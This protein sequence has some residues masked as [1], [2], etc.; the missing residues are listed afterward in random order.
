MKTANKGISVMTG[1]LNRALQGWSATV[2]AAAVVMLGA[3]TARAA[4]YIR[5]NNTDLLNTAAAWGGTLPTASDSVQWDATCGANRSTTLGG[6]VNWG[7][8]IVTSPGGTITIANT[9]SSTINLTGL[10]GTGIDMSAAT[11]NLTIDNPVA[12]QASQTWNVGA[13]RTLTVGNYAIS[14]SYGLTKS[15]SGTLT[16]SG[17]NTYTG[18]TTISGGVLSINGENR[19]G[20]TP[21]SATPGYLTFDGGTLKVTGS[22]AITLS[23]NR[24]VAITSNNGTIDNAMATQNFQING[25]ITNAPGHVGALTINNTSGGA[26]VPNSQ[27]TYS[28][29][30]TLLTGLTVPLVNSTGPAG[31][32]TSGPYGT[33]TL[34]L[35]GGQIRATT[36]V[37]ITIANPVVVANDTTFPTISNEKSLTFTGPVTLTGNRTL[38]VNIGATVSSSSLIISGAIGEDTAGRTLTKAGTGTLTLSTN[39]TYTGKTTVSGGTLSF[40]T[41]RNVN[42]GA[43]ALGAP[44]TVADGTVDVAGTLTY[45]GAALSSDRVINLTGNTTFY[46]NGSGLLTLTGGFTGAGLL[47]FRGAQSFAVSGAIT[48]SGGVNKTDDGT[49]TLSNAANSFGNVVINRGTISVNSIADA[50]VNSALGAGSTITLGQSGFNN[51]GKLQFTGAAGGASDRAINIQ[52]NSG[53]TNGGII[54]N[55]VAGQTLTLDGNVTTGGTGTTPSLQLTGAGN[56]VMSGTIAGSGLTLT[57]AGTGT[58][59]LS[60]D[61][62]FSGATTVSAGTLT[63]AGTGRLGGGSYAG[64]ITLAEG[65]TL[66]DDSTADQTLSSEISGAGALRKSQASTLTLGGVNTYTGMTTV[67]GG[68]LTLNGSLQRAKM[69]ITSGTVNGNGTI[70]YRIAGALSDFIAVSGSGTIN[71]ANLTLNVVQDD[72]PSAAEYVIIS[73]AGKVTG[74]SFGTVNLP[75]AFWSVDYDGTTANPGA[76][77]LVFDTA[78]ALSTWDGETSGSWALGQN[79][80]ANTTPMNGVPLLFPA[81]AGN[82]ANT[83]DLLTSVFSLALEGGYT[84]SGNALALGSSV[85][86]TGVN[87][88]ALPLS[89]GAGAGTFDVAGELTLSGEVSGAGGIAKTGSGTLVISGVNSYSGATAVSGGTLSM[90][91]TAPAAPVAG[92]ALWLDGADA[93]TFWADSVGGTPAS[94]GGAV[95]AWSDKSGNNY[96]TTQVT[97]DKRPTYQ[98][99]VQNGR[100]VLR[101]DATDDGMTNT[102]SVTSGNLTLFVVYTCR[103]AV[104][105]NRRVVQGSANWLIG[106]YG[107]YY[108][109]HPGTWI[110]AMTSPVLDNE[111]VLQRVIQGGGVASHFV[112]GA[113][114]G[115]VS[116]AIYPGTL[117]VGATTTYNEPIGGD[118]A[119]LLVYTTALTAEQVGAIE[120]YLGAKWGG[121]NSSIPSTKSLPVTTALSLAPGDLDLN[122]RSVSIGSLA[123]DASAQVRLNG[124]WLTAGNDNTTTT[125]SGTIING[126]AAGGGLYKDG[127]GDL[128]LA[129]GSANTFTGDTVLRRGR[130]GL[131]KTGGAALGGNIIGINNLSPDLYTT[132]DNQFA[133]GAVMYS[134]GSVTDYFRFELMGTTQTLAGIVDNTGRGVI[135]HREQVTTVPAVGPLSTLILNGS[136]TYVFNGHLRDNGGKL[137]LAMNGTGTQTLSGANITYTGTTTVNGG[138]LICT[139]GA[140]TG[141]AGSSVGV[142]SYMTINNG[143]T[144]DNRL[145]GPLTVWGTLR[146]IDGAAQTIGGDITLNGGALESGSAVG[147]NATYGTFYINPART[148]TANGAG[149]TISGSNNTIGIETGRTLT[150]DTPLATDA[151][152]V[153]G[154]IVRRND[155]STSTG[156]IA[157]NGA[158]TVTLSA[159]DNNYLGSTTINGGILS[160]TGTKTGAGAVTVNSGGTLAGTG[161]I[162]GAVTVAAGGRVAPGAGGVGKLTLSAARTLQPGSELVVEFNATP[163]NDKI[164]GAAAVT[165]NGGGVY[166]YAEG[167]TTPWTTP[168]VYQLIQYTGTPALANLSVLNP[169]PGLSYTFGTDGTWITL[170]LAA[171]SVSEWTGGGA[172]DNWNTSGNWTVTPTGGETL[173]FGQLDAVRQVNVNDFVGATFNG[174]FFDQ[175]GTYT[176]SGNAIS[177]GGSVVNL[178]PNTQTVNLNG[179]TMTG[180]RTFAAASGALVIGAPIGGA[181]GLNKTGTNALTL[182]NI[183]TYTGSTVVNEGSL[184]IGGSGQLNSGTYSGTI[185]LGTTASVFRYDSSANQTLDGVIS[186]SGSLVMSGDGTLTLSAAN[187]YTGGN[188]IH[189]DSGQ[190]TATVNTTQNS[191]GTGA[192]SVGAGSTLRLNNTTTSGTTTIGNV[193]TGAGRLQLNFAAAGSTR[194]TYMANVGG[195]EG[196]VELSAAGTS[197][198][199]W[200]VNGANA[201]SALVAIGSGSQL[202]INGAASTFSRVDAIG[203]GN[204]E[205]RGAIRLANTL[206]APVKLMGN[207]SI[208]PEGGTINGNISGGAAGPLLLTVGNSSTGNATFTGVLEDG[209][210]TL[211]LTKT[212]AGT[213]TLTGTNTYTGAT[214]I[215]AGILRVGSIADSG[216]ACNIGQGT[217]IALGGGTLQYTGG[218]V[219]MNRAIST[220]STTSGIDVNTAGTTLTIPVNIT[221]AGEIYKYGAGTLTLAGASSYT[222]NTIANGGVLNIPGSLTMSNGRLG[223]S[224]GAST[225]SVINVTGAVTA[226]RFYSSNASGAVNALNLNGGS[227]T[228]TGGDAD[229]QNFVVGIN[230]GGYGYFLNNGGTVSTA[231]FNIGGQGTHAPVGVVRLT[232]EGVIAT[233]SYMMMARSGGTAVFTIDNGT[234]DRSGITLSGRNLGLGW[235]ATAGR[236]ELNLNGGV[237]DNSGAGGV[238]HYGGSSSSS[239]ITG[240]VNLNAGRLITR[241]FAKTANSTAYLNFNGG[242]LQPAADATAFLPALTGV[243]VHGGGLTFDSKSYNTTIAA[244]L[245]A[246]TGNGVTTISVADGGSGYIGEPYVA[247]TDGA[248]VPATAI[249]NM[250]DDGTGNNTFKVGSITVTSQG[251]YM[252]VPTTVTVTGGGPAVAASGFTIGTAA[253]TSGGLTKTGDG[254][255]TLTGANTYTNTT[256]VSAGTLALGANSTLSSDT[257][258]SLGAGTL[259]VGVYSNAVS[260]LTV[261]GD[262]TINLGAG[263]KLVFADSA[264][265]TW[266]G[267]LIITGDFVDGASIRF[268]TNKEALTQQ[269]LGKIKKWGAPGY[270]LDENGFL[271]YRPGTRISFF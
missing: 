75:S 54:E 47:T 33:G 110:T 73:D 89:M 18:S 114:H 21:G 158:G 188:T 248:G 46:N 115:S 109:A 190:L 169:Q 5:Q 228:T 176:L 6:N 143:T 49:V 259:D 265:T 86:N 155:Q 39:N 142:N 24:G 261:T 102:L 37:A 181:Y 192:T 237:I 23:A 57:K 245:L 138:E 195:F 211:A 63:L 52:S 64:A 45:T 29:G 191:I 223:A 151:L 125:F 171:V 44:T 35:N 2:I 95:A 133:P 184:G 148:L 170:T 103:N 26:Y 213:L 206:N 224:E 222:G 214:T 193:F 17:A 244:E 124:A 88:L 239:T 42:G 31:A 197:G 146:A 132:A 198:D 201:P 243:Y 174:I 127:A 62:T 15:G 137:S 32:P 258:V 141:S 134:Y 56:G 200:N 65:A 246:P 236:A 179:L 168:G 182:N 82:K 212:A 215:N 80:L 78:A 230:T 4:D 257:P 204:S 85:A 16:L 152:T 177:L 36:S 10:S 270:I 235:D 187:T 104:S 58:W 164:S 94:P 217:A 69:T 218:S 84:I 226:L 79:W 238:V 219:S 159:T 12:L 120:N 252:V 210:G 8:I 160:F 30:T 144:S 13:S 38:T 186:G 9:A 209:L 87:E 175:N 28:G 90:G 74:S 205:N 130:L 116:T 180:T 105:A 50:G 97:A 207:T 266:P 61:N 91:G 221:G 267:T 77:V 106:P 108:R 208:G 131:G 167:T 40:N 3:A 43:S 162:T 254:A 34:T 48:I 149:N 234:L 202:F 203:T 66:H 172:N 140:Y 93:A 253:N 225:R 240:I 220:T 71:I 251:N 139:N 161:S 41:I 269:Q 154:R 229:M 194:N 216:V 178:T 72:L 231:R 189:A 157:K 185:G 122:G 150:F 165:I 1:M 271:V 96:H 163:A 99:G 242:T 98:A 14:G 250:V 128:I 117:N 196:T 101:F 70:N 249:A 153:S 51:T 118:V 241:S 112:N 123:G 264:L 135:Q 232:G 107:R 145:R 126:A 233:S 121:P 60:G 119:E 183:N 263:G 25:I 55:T 81:S 111:F 156:A 59:T 173:T 199:K 67:E 92:M 83:N 262:G 113:P 136:G 53:N 129:G 76:V 22:T 27:S 100:S 247:V 227:I 256:T 255:L 19:L 68:T 147:N 7:K 260:T 268:G 166:L 20:A 11:Q